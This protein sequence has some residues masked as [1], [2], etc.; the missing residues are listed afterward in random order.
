VRAI[1]VR[2]GS[3]ESET[4]AV[5]EK[6][7]WD[8]EKAIQDLSQQLTKKKF[9]L[10]VSLYWDLEPS[11][12]EAVIE[13]SDKEI[14]QKLDSLRTKNQ[15]EKRRILIEEEEKRILEEMK[16]EEERERERKLIREE[17]R[18]LAEEKKKS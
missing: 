10:Y 8:S 4:R 9:D 11:D 18:R 3:N 7:N 13:L 2:L 17:E 16:R 14:I 5:L 6:Y 1:V 12:I 15:E